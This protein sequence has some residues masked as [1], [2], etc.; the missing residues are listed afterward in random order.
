MTLLGLA[1]A[2]YPD[3]E[4]VV[5][6][7]SDAE[8]AARSRAVVTE[9]LVGTRHRYVRPERVLNMVAH[10][11][12]AVD[13]V[14][15]ADFVG[16]VTDR[17]TLVPQAV[18]L[19]DEVAAR[20][21]AEAVCFGSA[22][23]STA[24]GIDLP[25]IPPVLRA[26]PRASA[27]VLADFAQSRLRKDSPRFLNSF[28]SRAALDRIRA[29]Y[30]QIFGGIAPDYSFAF[31]FLDVVDNYR[32]I[33]APLLIDHSPQISNGMA[34]TRNIR[35]QASADFLARIKAEQATEFGLGP[36]PF[37]TTLLPSVILRE[38]DIA[39]H[40]GGA[41][42][43]L[44][45]VDPARFYLA[46]GGAVRRS[47]RLMDA[48]TRHTLRSLEQYRQRHGLRAWDLGT[49]LRIQSASIRNSIRGWTAGV[50]GRAAL[51]GIHR[52]IDGDGLLLQNLKA[53]R[54]KLS[55]PDGANAG[56][57]NPTETAR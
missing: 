42:S 32:F 38:L 45:Q 14:R 46:C 41:A 47:A 34:V 30:G 27:D 54:T 11:N 37:E 23:V 31:R 5:S 7:N 1:A 53:V 20:T 2:D 43:R 48:G 56:Q 26:E 17:M 55:L 15:G 16:F 25:A 52:G 44:P 18:S 57:A 24:N 19:C 28:C 29:R 3:L 10:W 33:E 40:Q 4:I 8:G 50:T 36:L 35:N 39:R 6:D 9:T 21:G 22:E 49:R 12:F 51:P 13:H